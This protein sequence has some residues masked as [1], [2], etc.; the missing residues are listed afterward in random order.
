[1]M[2]RKRKRLG[3]SRSVPGPSFDHDRACF[4]NFGGMWLDDGPLRERGT[5]VNRRGTSVRG[6]AMTGATVTRVSAGE[7]ERVLVAALAGRS[8]VLVGMMGAGKSAVGKRLAARLGFNFRD[9]DQ[10]IEAA[11]QKTIP[12]IFEA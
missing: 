2:V 12:E 8:I 10:E 3:I 9:A 1:M 4:G 5:R 11:A 6:S 7:R